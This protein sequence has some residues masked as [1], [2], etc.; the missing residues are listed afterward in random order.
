MDQIWTLSSD[1]DNAWEKWRGE[2]FRKLN[3]EEMENSSGQYTKNIGK[4]RRE[5]AS[6]SIWSAMRDRIDQFKQTLPLIQDLRSEALRPRHWAAL[7]KE[8]NKEFDP[9]GARFT[10][11]D[12]FSLGLHNYADFIG[13]LS[14]N[15]NKELNIERSLADIET[16]WADV[17]VDIAEY[18]E[19]YFKVRSTE[20]L[21]Q[22]LEDDSVALS[23]MKASKY[24]SAF[25]EKIDFW[26]RILS[27]ISEIVD[28]LLTV[29]RKWMYLE[30]IFM[31]AGDISKQLPEEYALFVSVN[32]GFK[33]VMGRVYKDPNAGRAC[34]VPGMLDEVT[35]FDNKLE[36]IQ[37]S[38]DQ[39][40]ETKR[41]LFPRF[42]FVSDDD[43]LEILGQSKEPQLVQKHIKKNFEG[44]KTLILVAP[45]K[46]MNR[47]YEASGGVSPEGE[48]MDF[49]SNVIVDGPVELWLGE[50]EKAMKVGL[51]KLLAGCREAYK[52]KK[53]EVWVKEWQGQLLITT[54]A[55]AWTSDCAK[56]LQ[57]ISGGNKGAMKGL[58]KKQ[59][60]Y[61]NRLTELV[62][63]P[64]L[65]GIDR[66]KTVALITMEIH[67]R[68]VM[69]RMIKANCS[70]VQDFEWLSQLRFE[71]KK[72]EGQFGTCIVKQTNCTL[73]YSY[74]YQGNN[75]RLVVT[76]LTDR[77]VLT[78]LTAMFLHRGGN[79]LGPAGTGKTETVKDLGKN[80][81][82][83][84]VVI[85][86]SDGMDY[87]SVGRIF[88]GLCQSGSWGCFD[89]FNRI[90]IEVISVVAMQIQSIV[91]AQRAHQSPFSFMG[92]I[93]P[94]SMEAG[95]FIT[96]NPG[97]AGRTELPDNLKALMRPVAMMAPDLNLIAEVMLASEGFAEARGLA[98][99]TITLYNLMQQQLSKQDHYDYGL[100]NL[101]AVLN[102]A[103]S[104][105]RAD[106]TVN[107]EMIL[108][109][110]LRD[111][112]LPKFI[113]D[114][115]K[116]FKLLLGD[117][118]PGLDL[119]VSEYGNLA[120][121]LGREL[122]RKGLQ[123]HPF[124]ISKIIQLYDSQLTRHCNMLVGGSLSGK[125]AV[126]KTLTEAKTSMCKEDKLPDANVV[127][128]FVINAKAITLS[129]LYGAYDLQTFEWADGILST[130]FKQ[131]SENDKPDEK[132][133]LFD[134][135]VDAMWIESMNSVMDDNKILTLINGDRIPLTRSMTLLFEVED[136]AVA[137]PATV[138]RAGMIY[139]DPEG[140]GWQ[141]YVTSW[142]N[143]KYKN[144]PEDAQF[145]RDMFTK[146]I[147]KILA[148]KA[149]N[150]KEPV[151]IND[152]NAVLSFI[153]LYEALTTA[154]NG[155]VR[156]EGEPPLK[157][158]QVCEKW[159]AFCVIWTVMAAVDEMGR[160]R[161]D[162]YLR[163]I[164]AQ[165][166]PMHTVYDYFI[167][168]KKN[169]FE[170]WET[171]LTNWRP[172]KGL[173]FAQLIVPT[174]DTI[175]NSFF[176]QTM[177]TAKH[178]VLISGN[179]GTGKTVLCQSILEQLPDKCSAL[180]VN[181]SS[182]TDSGTTQGIVESAM[183]KRSKDKIGPS[184]GKQ[185]V[186]FID[187]FNMPKKTNFES[188]FQPPLELLRLWIDYGG[189]YDRQ[190]CLWK[191]VLDTQIVAAMAPPTGGREVISGRT[192]SR[193]ALLYCT[194]PNDGQIIRIFESILSP[195]LSE[196]ENEIKPLGAV[197]AKATL[198][199]YKDV[200]Q[201]FFPTPAKS[202]Y[203]FNLRDVA[204]VVQGIYQSSKTFIDTKD[205]MIRLWA[206]ECSE[207]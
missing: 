179:T 44:I 183:E 125:S 77:C 131:C 157:F 34:S 85:N 145:H 164:E 110:A 100:R 17:I 53:K 120:T 199:V 8:I 37:K 46:A 196:F 154:E 55:I 48:T 9:D 3:V 184:G 185:L 108:M 118:F 76:P 186:L 98:K 111:M 19:I 155:V 5:I 204:K 194:Q 24:Y 191:Y 60:G 74:E 123:K 122:D 68:D 150:C 105:K 102:M 95:I 58:K 192:Q 144:S 203:L 167:D 193:F 161:L 90:K 86:C 115:L 141:P 69:E 25:K 109:R 13:E 32:D 59:I 11:E 201:D 36:R 156:V 84:V 83:Y 71:F 104:L 65:G 64:K 63:D 41:M 133:I 134:G 139:V 124:L 79:P 15:A 72:D 101:K 87:K 35:D 20:D 16:R 10:L 56:G 94:C 181:F 148:F 117:L 28:M 42:Y 114:D 106:P 31:A 132:W 166:P 4:L 22:L 27:T 202:H 1:W 33:K 188:P 47:T 57:S 175:R 187:D 172:R 116:L 51:S 107:E 158:Y 62:R 113:E 198:Q 21:F 152:F 162:Q 121:A 70:N 190:K 206:H 103:G 66:N 160:I 171:K 38:L 163:E 189:W 91:N 82:K 99:K 127:T 173:Q 75:G 40:L 136:L 6:W 14:S 49:H 143:K 54:G 23:T 29:Q 200:C 129:E 159:F 61:L 128:M 119:P 80:L 7:K 207:R 205:S 197:I 130:T 81:A 39:Y 142:I 45:G 50:V 12:I 138:S 165:F 96:M 52:G 178:R 169:D 126:W 146:Y 30:S 43:L 89:E 137:S 112:N 177:V 147:A 67:N 135:P 18:K 149:V 97:Y 195:K 93:I 180:V 174:I 168:P 153:K 78:L 151:P 2:L 26:E 170:L 88:S 73:S 92:Q 182:A 176:L 140:L